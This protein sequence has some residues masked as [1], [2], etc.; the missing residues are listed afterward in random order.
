MKKQAIKRWITAA[1]AAGV[2]LALLLLLLISEKQSPDASITGLPSALWY[3]LTTLTTVGYGDLYP[4][5][6]AGK[7]IGAVFQLFSL[8]LL[9]FLISL[10]MAAMRGMV[11]PY[12]KLVTHP[13]KNVYYL[14]AENETSDALAAALSQEDPDGV[15]LYDMAGAGE[16]PPVGMVSQLS[17]ETVVRLHGS[18]KTTILCM[19][20][21]ERKNDRDAAAM[22]SLGTR[23]VCVSDYE[24]EKVP[25]GQIRVHRSSLT[26]RAYWQRFPV[27]HKDETIVIIGSG[28]SAEDLLEYGLTQNV[29][30]LDQHLRYHV[31]GDLA[32]F[33]RRHPGLKDVVGIDQE[34]ESG[35]AV[36]FHD[37]PW[38]ADLALL[39]AADRIVFCDDDTA[40]TDERV[41]Q[42][43]RCLPARGAVHARCDNEYDHVETFGSLSEIFSPEMVLR[44]KLSRLA[45]RLNDI[46]RR[47]VG[48]NAPEW[49][50]LGTF[51]RRSN[52]ASAD[53]L[54]VKA[55]ILLGDE[56]TGVLTQ[57]RIRKAAQ[58]F[59]AADEKERRKLRMIEHERWVRFHVLN[60]WSYAP[61]R[62]NAAWQHPM[63]CPFD[64]LT[65]ADQAKDDFSWQLFGQLAGA[66]GDAGE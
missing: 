58:A 8:G 38:D 23:L 53:H 20:E 46:Y 13:R 48:G 28:R 14:T 57:E 16:R 10:V 60:N 62:N 4:V 49:A 2:Y 45:I 50:G 41:V 19:D 11:R 59:E 63:I 15:I 18:E 32:G 22:E 42:F 5:T 47:Q 29:F 24:P 65:P 27:L 51:L 35:D 1:A 37:G 9:A 17:A 3:S 52:L 43:L 6:G 66:E 12:L 40:A 30:A 21:D 34:K 54:P 25:A 33:L 7:V 26:A 44:V 61:V 39:A 64:D 36:F 31:F 55:R 56:E